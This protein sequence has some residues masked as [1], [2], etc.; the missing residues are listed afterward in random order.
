ML[1]L[2]HCSTSLEL[3][4]SPMFPLPLYWKTATLGECCFRPVY[5]FPASASRNPAGCKVLRI[6]D[7]QNGSVNWDTV[8][9]THV[10]ESLKKDIRLTRGD[11]VVAR[12]GATTG[13][14]FLISDCPDAVFAS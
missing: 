8:P 12:I 7:I 2:Q 4:R 13:K 6:T 3:G 10:P 14:A 11:I 1:S 9:Y 5:G